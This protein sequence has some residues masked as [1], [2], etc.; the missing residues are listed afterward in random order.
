MSASAATRFSLVYRGNAIDG[1]ISTFI[2][3]TALR[4]QGE[5]SFHPICANQSP[6]AAQLESW[7]GTHILLLDLSLGPEERQKMLDSGILSIECRDHHESS[8]PHWPAESGAID[9]SICTSIAVWNHW[10]SQQ[11][12]PF[13]LYS[14]D[15]ISRWDNPTLEDRILREVLMVIARLPPH[16][17]IPPTEAFM[18]WAV[19]P[20]CPEFTS[21]M[22]QGYHSLAEKDQIL[23]QLLQTHGRFHQLREEDVAAW[24]LSGEWVG[25]RCF[26]LDNSDFIID[27]NEAAFLTFLHNPAINVFINY[28]KKPRRDPATGKL[29]LHYLYSAR[30]RPNDINLTSGGFF[31]GH[32]SSAGSSVA[33]SK[34]KVYP[35]LPIVA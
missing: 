31:Q 27:T 22:S 21:L 25:A 10:Y 11:E 28:R 32:S 23:L 29:S 8:L 4:S 15:R 34:G 19:S 14:V 6:N 20:H 17:A 12:K 26:L 3:Y 2:A 35:F 9:S 1:W 30:A 13:W 24:G 33:I 16:D 5:V 7:K 18:A